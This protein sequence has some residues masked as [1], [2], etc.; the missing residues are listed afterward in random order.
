MDSA[1]AES[2]DV[3]GEGSSSALSVLARGSGAQEKLQQWRQRVMSV[4]VE[5]EAN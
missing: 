1:S 5:S 4:A 3:E 2:G